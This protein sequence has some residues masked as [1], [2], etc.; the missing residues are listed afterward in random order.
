MNGWWGWPLR[1]I[2]SLQPAQC[3]LRW[4]R[5]RGDD[6]RGYARRRDLSILLIGRSRAATCQGDDGAVTANC[7]SISSHPETS[8]D[9]SGFSW[10]G[11]SLVHRPGRDVV[12]YTKGDD[13]VMDTMKIHFLKADFRGIILL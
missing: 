2:S 11:E 9:D 12:V 1:V 5:Q 8:A 6:Q 13:G 7:A 10:I 4:S 3:T